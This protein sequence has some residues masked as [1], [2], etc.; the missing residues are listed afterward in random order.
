MKPAANFSG[1]IHNQG[2]GVVSRS[3]KNK[4]VHNQYSERVSKAVTLSILT[5]LLLFL[6]EVVSY[7]LES[8]LPFEISLQTV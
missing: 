5:I 8:L 6:S 7:L 3:E 1:T 2:Q 4:I